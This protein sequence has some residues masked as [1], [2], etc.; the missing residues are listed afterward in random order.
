MSSFYPGLRFIH[1]FSPLPVTGG[2]FL[3]PLQ[4]LLSEQGPGPV[5]CTPSL[6]GVVPS[7]SGIIT[8]RRNDCNSNSYA[9]KYLKLVKGTGRPC[10]VYVGRDPGNYFFEPAAP[11]ITPIDWVKSGIISPGIPM[12]ISL[13]A[14][15]EN[16]LEPSQPS[17]KL[18]FPVRYGNAAASE[19]TDWI[20][21][22]EPT[23]R[24][25]SLNNELWASFSMAQGLAMIITTCGRERVFS[26]AGHTPWRTFLRTEGGGSVQ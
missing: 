11:T 5:L 13:S 23:T 22:Q 14:I 3:H 19:Q 18:G 6:Q 7:K 9:H 21:A 15:P 1:L 26:Q 2:L 17:E 4:V 24:P 25:P 12:T 20:P 8:T 10:P 16:F